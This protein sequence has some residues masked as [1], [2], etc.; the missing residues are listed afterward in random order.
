MRLLPLSTTTLQKKKQIINFNRGIKL[1]TT[2]DT[3][4][5]VTII[6]TIIT[7]A[8]TMAITATTIRQLTISRTPT[9]KG[10]RLH[11]KPII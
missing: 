6:I 4:I 1:C 3:T 7:M 8:T 11:L 2:T 10:M 5:T 9:S